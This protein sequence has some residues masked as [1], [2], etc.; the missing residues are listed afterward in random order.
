[1]FTVQSMAVSV[2]DS[3]YQACSLCSWCVGF[4]YEW[5][6]QVTKQCETFP[7]WMDGLAELPVL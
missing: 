3:K 5:N 6:I 1:M 2:C 4:T 7:V